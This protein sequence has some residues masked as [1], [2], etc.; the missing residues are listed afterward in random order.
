MAL[1]DSVKGHLQTAE[2]SLRAALSFASRQERPTVC[3]ALA[4][5]INDVERVSTVDETQDN[6]GAIMNKFNDKRDR[7]FPF[8]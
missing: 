1:S 4:K 7:G 6:L 2:E 3:I 5:L 8:I